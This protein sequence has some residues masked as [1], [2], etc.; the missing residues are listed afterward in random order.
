MNIDISKISALN[1]RFLVMLSTGRDSVCMT[2]ILCKNYD[3]S[4]MVFVYLWFY[5]EGC[6]SYRDEY[7]KS[8]EEKYGIEVKYHPH[9]ECYQINKKAPKL[10]F[11]AQRDWLMKKYNCTRTAYGWRK[12]ESFQRNIIL[13]HAPGGVPL[14]KPINAQSDDEQ[15]KDPQSHIYPLWNINESELE[16]YVIENKIE[17]SIE[18]QYGLRD[19]NIYSGVYA[20]FL[21]DVFPKDFEMSCKYHP[22]LKREY[23]RVISID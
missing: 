11:S 1:E 6:L 3:K 18:Y 22:Q 15:Y 14:D 21:H 12:G 7:I 13:K 8:I 5:P 2:D 16:R 9:F 4:K 23:H 17:L 20:K 19:I 10:S